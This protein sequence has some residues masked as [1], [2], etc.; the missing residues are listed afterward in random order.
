MFYNN[1]IIRELSPKDIDLV[2]QLQEEIFYSLENHDILRRNTKEMFELCLQEPNWTIGAFPFE[3]PKRLVGIAI[4]FDPGESEENIANHLIHCKAKKSV[5]A[6]LFMIHNDF[7]G[8]GF[9]RMALGLIKDRAAIW[10]Y[11]VICTT[12]SP[13]NEYSK[14]NF[15]SSGYKYDHT[16]IKYGGL[17]REV[18]YLKIK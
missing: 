15:I 12:V 14:R 9:Q 3:A 17:V 5:N 11:D 2:L 18:Y 8:K 4:L 6:K 16:E 7:K 1:L 10:G 13:L